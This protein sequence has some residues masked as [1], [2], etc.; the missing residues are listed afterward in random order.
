MPTRKNPMFSILVH[1][2]EIGLKKNNRSFFEKKFI[3][4]LSKHISELPHSKIKLVSA[5]ILIDNIDISK[6]S[7]YKKRLSYAMGLAN[8]TLMIKTNTD[9][10]EIKKAVEFLLINSSFETFRVTTKRHYK[11]FNKTSIQTNVDIGEYIQKKTKKSVNLSNADENFIIEI[12][13]DKSYVG[14]DKIVGFSGLPSGS[15]E[16]AFSLISSGIDS[17]VA[18][19]EMIKRGVEVDYVHFHSHPATNKQSINNVKKI[20]NEL[21]KYQLKSKLYLVPLLTLQQKI[22]GM[23]E[24]KYWVIFFRRA[25]VKITNLIALK[26]KGVALITGES[27]GQVA[28]Q[29]LSNIRAISSVSELPIIRPLAGLNKDEIIFKAKKINTYDLSIKP[30][31]DCCSFFVP[32]HPETKAKM[33]CIDEIESKLDLDKEINEVINNIEILEFDY[34]ELLK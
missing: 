33:D 5:R 11:G 13:K 12:L 10:N 26:N 17:P 8:A 25:M 21:L 3:N 9:I 1:Y 31:D 16:K 24:D 29:T 4:N 22:M 15:Q 32:I 20:L 2:S 6:W 30:Y 23:V 7:E 27:V 28:S 34:K 19:F 18:S 14:I